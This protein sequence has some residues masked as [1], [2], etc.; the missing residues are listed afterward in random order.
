M[1]EFLTIENLERQHQAAPDST[2]FAYLAAR[3]V[4]MGDFDKAMEIASPGV[5]KHP[6]FAFG[7]YVLALAHYYLKNFAEARDQMEQAL[8]LD[9][10]SPQAWKFLADVQQKLGLSVNAHESYLRYFLADQF[11]EEAAEKFASEDVVRLSGSEPE[12]L[13]VDMSGEAETS[14]ESELPEELIDQMLESAEEDEQTPESEIDALLKETFES[15]GDTV[16]PPEKS[17][18]E[19]VDELENLGEF[20]EEETE[21]EADEKLKKEM[22]TFFEEYED[23]GPEPAAE[24]G[25]EAD[26][27]AEQEEG[28]KREESAPADQPEEGNERDFPKEFLEEEPMDFSAVVADIISEGD[29]EKPESGG[30]APEAPEEQA[31]ET[32][33]ETPEETPEEELDFESFISQEA[34]SAP[35][36]ASTP[37]ME[38]PAEK[39][40]EAEPADS[41][42]GG[43]E[44]VSSTPETTQEE[45]THFGRPPL[46]SPTL[47]EI[48][49]SQGRLEEAIEVFRQLLEKEPNNPRFKRKIED[50]Q[51]I[52]DRK[53]AADNQ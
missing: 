41:T 45:T 53:N 52:I 37:E 35:S 42:G 43:E 24:S 46:L 26:I 22:D 13:G 10:S 36:S 34:A 12:D 23:K 9:P 32:P 1:A 16:A 49:I 15:I 27:S 25:E 29:T 11:S 31:E 39:A 38:P 33:Q 40:P 21:D 48:Y 28:E 51:Q 20:G 4:E 19:V 2:L 30:A 7:H 3:Y 50:L 8:A 17:G 6:N 44:A 47:G 5:E 18:Q 14:A